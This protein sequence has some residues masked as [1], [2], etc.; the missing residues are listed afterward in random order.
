[1]D[2][3]PRLISLSPNVSMILF[4]LGADDALL[5]RTEYCLGSI[6][7]Y[8]KVW[9]IS[10]AS[11]D[12][13]FAK[14]EQLPIIGTWPSAD[15]ERVKA[16]EPDAIMASGSGTLAKFS[17]AT[18]G[19]AE[20]Q[21]YNFDVRTFDDLYAAIGQLARLLK[22]ENQGERLQADLQAKTAEIVASHISPGPRPTVLFE[23]CVCIK[24]DP[25][26]RK[27]VANPSRHI[28]VG[29][30]LAPE[31]I[32]LGG[33]KPLFV[34]PGD[35]ARWVSVRDIRAAQPDVVLRFDCHGCLNAMNYPIEKRPGWT[36]LPAVTGNAVFTI[37]ENISNPNLCFPASLAQLVGILNGYA[38]MK[39]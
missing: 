30:H 22:Q 28:M 8:L 31:L 27:R 21:F 12:D 6:K 36:D 4:A 32:Q 19:I 20:E 18:F 34:Q 35:E 26:P 13:R 11:V 5:G 1:M 15:P 2:S 39:N 9:G 10:K 25:D 37:T 29:G 7:K 3:A 33:G 14:W 38:T 23:Y 16:L 24:F 17:A